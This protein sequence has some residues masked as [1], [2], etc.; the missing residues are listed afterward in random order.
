MAVV[1]ALIVPPIFYREPALR[2]LPKIFADSARL[3]G[4]IGLIIGLVVGGGSVALAWLIGSD[5]PSGP[6]A[7]AAAVI[8]ALRLRRPVVVVGGE[9]TLEMLDLSFNPISKFYEAPIQM[10]ANGGVCWSPRSASR[11]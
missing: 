8:R 5:S 4:V 2:D 6:A 9:L 3:S 11:S 10:K 1:Y 7:D